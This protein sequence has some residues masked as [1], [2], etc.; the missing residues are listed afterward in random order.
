MQGVHIHI[1]TDV[2]LLSIVPKNGAF[3]AI[4]TSTASAVLPASFQ[5]IY[6]SL[7]RT[8]ILVLYTQGNREG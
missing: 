6:D 2:R 3:L 5:A 1:G 4:S 8:G 7:W